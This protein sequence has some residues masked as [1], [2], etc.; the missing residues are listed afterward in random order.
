MSPA[1]PLRPDKDN[2]AKSNLQIHYPYKDRCQI[3]K[4]ILAN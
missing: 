1:K 2:T 4:K 3:L